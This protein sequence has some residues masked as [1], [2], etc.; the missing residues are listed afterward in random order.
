MRNIEVK[1][2]EAHTIDG[3]PVTENTLQ[4]LSAL[5]GSKSP[6]Q[7]PRGIDNFR[8]FSRIAKAF[9][10]AETSGMIVLEESDYS[11]LK[12]TVES[13]IPAV[14]ALNPKRVEAIGLFLDAP[15]AVV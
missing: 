5:V 4:A 1:T 12:K 7:M 3:Q 8:L 10:A 15:V 14:W 11:F 6:E 13:D 9:E 2:W